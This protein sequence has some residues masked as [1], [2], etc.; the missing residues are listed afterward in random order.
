MAGNRKSRSGGVR[1]GVSRSFRSV[2][3]PASGDT[4]S[5][6]STYILILLVPFSRTE[7]NHILF[8]NA[9]VDDHEAPRRI[10]RKIEDDHLHPRHKIRT[11]TQALN[12]RIGGIGD[13]RGD[14]GRRRKTYRV[15]QQGVGVRREIVWLPKR[16]PLH[17]QKRRI[18]RESSAAYS[19]TE[20][21]GKSLRRA[22]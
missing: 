13:I 6:T 17:N 2:R 20:C 8:S 4:L 1:S 16:N 7:H 11:R 19:V 15:N 12:S 21:H 3:R 5:Q 14:D 10:H 22:S 18:W 9:L